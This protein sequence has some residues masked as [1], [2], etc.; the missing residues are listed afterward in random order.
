MNYG[1][2]GTKI[3]K[4]WTSCLNYNKPREEVGLD[5][6]LD[7]NEDSGFVSLLKPALEP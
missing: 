6:E 1:G 3:N 5:N 4:V 2:M 7:G